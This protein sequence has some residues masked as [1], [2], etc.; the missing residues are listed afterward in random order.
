MLSPEHKNMAIKNS[1]IRFILCWSLLLFM[2]PVLGAIPGDVQYE[3]KAED[4]VDLAAENSAFPPA[5]FPHW[6][7]RINYRCDAC[8]DSLFEMKRG[9]TPVTMDLIKK[10]EVCGTCHNHTLAFGS[11]FESCN[12]CH[13]VPEE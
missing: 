8:H 3:R 4:G 13:F 5:V 1:V 9:G 2:H 7:H 10:G 6:K 11:D 12:R